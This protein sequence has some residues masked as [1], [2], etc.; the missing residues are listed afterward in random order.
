MPGPPANVSTWREVTDD[1][2]FVNNNLA[3]TSARMQRKLVKKAHKEIRRWKG[4]NA[5]G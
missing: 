4:L 3:N 1:N 2:R 5:G